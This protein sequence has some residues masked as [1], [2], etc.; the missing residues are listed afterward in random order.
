MLSGTVTDQNGA[1][2]PGVSVS[3]VN[4]GTQLTRDVT[5]DDEG[6]FTVPLLP[7]GQYIVRARRDGFAPTDFTDIVLNVGD[8]KA[9]KIELR[10]GDVS[11]SV[12]VAT[13]APL[14]DTSAAV[15]TTVDRTFVG[16]LPLN[17]RSFQSLI[18]LTPGVV[19]ASSGN[20]TS[21]GQFSVNGQRTNSNY[22]TVDG[23]SVNAGVDPRVSSS[24]RESQSQFQSGTVPG[25][26]TFGGTNNLVS[27]DAL[28]EFK[29]QTSTY[30]AEF[31]RQ[32]GGQVQ[33]VTR[34][35][36]NEFH[37]TAFEYVRNEAFDANNWF[38]NSRPLTAQQVAAGITK[39]PRPPLRQNQ[40]G[41]TFGGP[42]ML[43]RF[44]EGGKPYW[45]GRN[46]SFFFFSYEGLRLLLP[47]SGSSFVPS[48]RLRQVAAPAVR[49]FLNAFALP[50]GPEVLSATGQPLGYSPITY[51]FSN[52]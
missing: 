29:I 49:P 12:Q 4:R 52:P 3:V 46:K 28:E 34:S 6:S 2:I 48:I 15:T 26:T 13:D 45:S 38:T 50:T 51:S 7:P 37:G 14:I 5:T 1:T 25:L 32:P 11:A 17:G 21:P 42:V 20:Q 22:F 35:G 10:A 9:L 27:V 16:N 19:V 41:G 44:G 47:Q 39:Q 36:K 43:P 30:S 8:Q 33:L 18:L 40:F 31:G 24:F 23:V